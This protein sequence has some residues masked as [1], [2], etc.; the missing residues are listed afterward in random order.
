MQLPFR[1]IGV[2]HA[3]A[4]TGSISRAAEE[5]HVTPS[6][7][8]QQIQSLEAQLGTALTLK[9]GRNVALTEAGERFYQMIGREVDR[10]AEATDWVRGFRSVTTLVVRAAPSLSTKWLL[11][12]LQD[13]VSAHPNIEVRLDGTTEPT[14]FGKENVDIEIRH[15]RGDWPG[16]YVEGLAEEYFFPLCAP[17]VAKAG[18]LAACELPSQR[19]IHSVKSQ[20]QWPQ[21]FAAAQVAPAERWRRVLFDRTH[22]AIDYAAEGGG[23]AL[24]SNLMAWRELATGTLVCPVSHPPLVPITTQ[25]IVCPHDHLRRGKNLAFLDWVREQRTAWAATCFKGGTR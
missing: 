4:R 19:L 25:W 23:I 15:G 12:L 22:M 17:Q 13:F 8:T 2:F 10:I 7:V 3:V 24:E 16:L 6:A 14:S 1:A 9:V 21:W 11:P 5:L 20:M 18:S